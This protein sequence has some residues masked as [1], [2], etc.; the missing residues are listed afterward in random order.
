MMRTKQAQSDVRTFHAAFGITIGDTPAIRDAQ[1]REDLLTE[2]LQETI[3]AIRQNR[4]PAA[5]DG[6]CDLIYVA[7][8]TAV[9][10]GVELELH[11]RAVHSANMR[12]VGGAKRADGKQLKPDG[13]TAPDHIGLLE[14]QGWRNDYAENN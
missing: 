4:L 2:E 8:G 10:F 3:K 11:F 5:I 6:L 1:L 14:A 7:L 13:W 9:T 12:K